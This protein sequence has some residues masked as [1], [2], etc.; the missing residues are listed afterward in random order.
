[1]KNKFD[2]AAYELAAYGDESDYTQFAGLFS[3]IKKKVSSTV[4]SVAKVSTGIVPVEKIVDAANTVADKAAPIVEKYGPAAALAVGAVYAPGSTALLAPLLKGVS[5]GS[6]Q[7]VATNLLANSGVS[8]DALSAINAMASGDSTKI[9]ATILPSIKAQYSSVVSPDIIERVNMTVAAM[10]AKGYT[11]SQVVGEL[12]N[13]D[14]FKGIAT[15]VSLPI[16]QSISSAYADLQSGGNPS[17]QDKAVA[18]ANAQGAA[19]YGAEKAGSAVPAPS[20]PLDVKTII[21]VALAV[22]SLMKG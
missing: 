14:T 9:A 22:F 4:K 16:L 19:V 17:A 7:A 20:T 21:P 3:K 12:V 1:M 2:L 6:A 13:S 18:A 10:K 8:P 11:D 15:S 5:S